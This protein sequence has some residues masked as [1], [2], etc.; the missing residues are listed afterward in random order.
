MGVP[1]TFKKIALSFDAT[2]NTL[3]GSIYVKFVQDSTFS[4]LGGLKE[5]GPEYGATVGLSKGRLNELS[6]QYAPSDGTVLFYIPETP[7]ISVFLNELNG[8]VDHLTDDKPT[9]FRL[10]DLE[11]NDPGL[12]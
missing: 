6:F 12:G 11:L 1:I 8:G 5:D 2:K 3:T 10:G 4:P 7:P 9:E